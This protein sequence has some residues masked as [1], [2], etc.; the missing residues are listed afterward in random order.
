[1]L[2]ALT[3]KDTLKKKLLCYLWRRH[4]L[5]WGVGIQDFGKRASKLEKGG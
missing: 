3:P 1:M 2:R 4:V 5:A